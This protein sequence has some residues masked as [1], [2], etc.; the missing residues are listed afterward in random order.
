MKSGE[1]RKVLRAAL[2]PG[3][4][5]GGH[6]LLPGGKAG[7]R[8]ADKRTV[9]ELEYISRSWRPES[10]GRL[11]AVVRSGGTRLAANRVLDAAQRRALAIRNNERLAALPATAEERAAFAHNYEPTP[12]DV[13]P[14]GHIQLRF[15]DAAD[16]ASWAEFF[17]P[18]IDTLFAGAQAIGGAF[19]GVAER[20]RVTDDAGVSLVWGRAQVGG[21]VRDPGCPKHRK[22]IAGASPDG[23]FIVFRGAP[24]FV[25][26]EPSEQWAERWRPTL[27]VDSR[28]AVHPSGQSIA[29]W[30]PGS[31]G[32][33]WLLSPEGRTHGPVLVEPQPDMDWVYSSTFSGDGR[34]LWINGR[35]Q[36]QDRLILLDVATFTVLDTLAPPSA[37]ETIYDEGREGWA[38]ASL[39]ADPASDRV[40]L[41]QNGG[42]SFLKISVHRRSDDDRIETLPYAVTCATEGFDTA[43]VG[44]TAFDGQGGIV[45]L[46]SYCRLWRWSGPDLETKGVVTA[47]D[48][49]PDESERTMA[50]VG[51]VGST[52]LVPLMSAEGSS[53]R[54]AMVGPGVPGASA[55]MSERV[56]FPP[57]VHPTVVGDR[58]LGLGPDRCWVCDRWTVDDDARGPVEDA[59]AELRPGTERVARVWMR[60]GK[61][62][63]LRTHRTAWFI[64][65]EED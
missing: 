32:G 33:L 11:L 5:K 64:P 38:E 30:E 60:R 7:L 43:P 41:T 59:I 23:R 9:F 56:A 51:A 35:H 63:E 25:V 50:A 17:L 3:A 13:G 49:A 46:D 2:E 57:T 37:P 15:A 52:L 31:P 48:P 62:W 44:H 24:D 42:D 26:H 1:I 28:I 18:R 4:T 39:V 12:Q 40:A 20:G 45:G 10:G 22:A 61:G 55:R 19:D 47:R 14:L 65:A 58:I 53:R 29:A 36:Q 54:V 27:H 8:T 34:S 6:T 16:L 21:L